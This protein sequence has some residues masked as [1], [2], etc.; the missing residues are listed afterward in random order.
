MTD[1]KVLVTG[2]SGKLGRETLDSLLAS[3]KAPD[4]IIATT[5]TVE[6]LADYA[7]KGVDVRRADFND[8]ASLAAAFAGAARIAI[9]STDAIDPGSDRVVQHAAAVEAAKKAGADHLIYTSLPDPEHSKISFAPDHLGSEKAI[10]ASGLAYTILRNSWYQEN[11]LMSL[12]HAFSQGV[13][14]SA[15]GNG[16]QSFIGH[17]DCARAV[18][19]ALLSES[20]ESRILTLNDGESHTVDE[21]AALASS[22]TGKPLKVEHISADALREGL[23]GA[24]LPPFV[25]DLSVSAD[26][27]IRV[28]GFDI[29]NDDFERLTGMKPRSLRAF[30]EENKAAF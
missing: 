15:A 29:V 10:I 26:E 9:I 28:G 23:A 24:G 8:P 12:P 25:V 13:W 19:A 1:T 27:N 14:A 2:A 11:L 21:I 6:K 30:F 7:K 4:Q 16:K 3:G 5:R 20:G 18:A 17:A 22:V